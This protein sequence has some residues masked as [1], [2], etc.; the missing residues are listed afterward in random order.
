MKIDKIVFSSSELYSPFWNIQ[1]KIWKTKF[2]IHPVCLLYGDKSKCQMSEE[3]G[4]VIETQFDKTIPDILQI[5]FGK[6][7]HPTTEPETTWLVG[8]IDMIPMQ[9]EYFFNIWNNIPNDDYCHL[10]YSMI[11]QMWEVNPQLLI[12]RG[13]K[14]NGGYD[15]PGHHHCGKGKLFKELYFPN[16]NMTSVISEIVKSGRYRMIFGQEEIAVR[17]NNWCAEETY[18]TQKI[19]EH[20]KK[21]E[22][23]GVHLYGYNRTEHSFE[24]KVGGMNHICPK[25][26]DHDSKTHIYDPIKVTQKQY[27]EMHCS[28]PYKDQEESMLKVL[29]LAQMI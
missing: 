22:W 6:F 10:N 23:N 2:N 28:F 19:W 27:I 5:Q 18:T 3:Y 17:G 11:A 24:A 15:L 4:E 16:T 21:R 8:D 12:D 29:S 20:F 1:S 25:Y 13:S 26:Y 14:L 9:T 7:F